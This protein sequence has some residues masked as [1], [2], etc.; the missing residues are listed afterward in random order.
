MSFFDETMNSLNT[1][2]KLDN[3]LCHFSPNAGIIVEVH[4]KILELSSTKINLLC[5]NA[6]RLEIMGN[7]LKIEHISN[8]EICILG[9]IISINIV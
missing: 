9:T 7:N 4:K 3:I 1:D 5:S 2:H 6:K 8:Q